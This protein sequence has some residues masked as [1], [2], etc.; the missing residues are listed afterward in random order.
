VLAIFDSAYAQ[1]AIKNLHKSRYWDAANIG[2]IETGYAY[3]LIKTGLGG[4]SILQEL[5]EDPLPSI[6]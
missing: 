5:E 6:C 1:M 2:R 3:A 4:E